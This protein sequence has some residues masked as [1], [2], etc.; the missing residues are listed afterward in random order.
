MYIF[1]GI[2]RGAAAVSDSVCGGV[3]QGVGDDVQEREVVVLCEV[4]EKEDGRK[5][6][7]NKIQSLD[8]V[9]YFLDLFYCMCTQFPLKMFTFNR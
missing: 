2:Q 6:Q 3:A 9:I 5:K 4:E 7:T 8:S 1:G